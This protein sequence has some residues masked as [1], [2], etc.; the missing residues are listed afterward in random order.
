[1]KS[2]LLIEQPKKYKIYERQD[3]ISRIRDRFNIK[4]IEDNYLKDLNLSIK[5]ISFPMNLNVDA[6]MR[7]METAKGYLNKEHGIVAPKVWRK[8]DYNIYNKFQKELLAYSIVSSMQLILRLKNK[9][10]RNSCIVI[11]DP[12]DYHIYEGVLCLSKFAK[13]IVFLTDN[14][15][16]AKILADYVIANY[17]ISPIITRDKNHALKNA[18]FIL[19]SRDWDLIIDKPIWTL[20]NLF[21]TF[22]SGS[23]Y[24]NDVTYR[25]PWFGK[26]DISIELLG[27]ILCQMEEKDIERSLKYNGAFLNNIMF[28]EEVLI[29]E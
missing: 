25:T 6:Y 8:M 23:Q 15:D 18:D 21:S 29:F 19:T 9:S 10:I 5:K 28:N 17:G 26:D 22:N 1:M 2:V 24:I 13:Y 11:Y 14:I 20:D 12:T 4:L 16:K 27:A 3:I 7:N